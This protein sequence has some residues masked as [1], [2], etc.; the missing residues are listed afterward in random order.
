M[1]PSQ[2]SLLGQKQLKDGCK[3]PVDGL[4]TEYLHGDAGNITEPLKGYN[5]LA[6]FRKLR[7]LFH[8]QGH[9]KG[10]DIPSSRRPPWTLTGLV[11]VQFTITGLVN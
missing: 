2:A 6:K 3:N 8:G 10:R 1:A 9:V 11:T 7:G 4:A 5:P